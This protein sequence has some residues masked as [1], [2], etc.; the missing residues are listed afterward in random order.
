MQESC[1]EDVSIVSY[2]PA[3]PGELG[4]RVVL[5]ADPEGSLLDP[6]PDPL[7][8]CSHDCPLL[9]ARVCSADGSSSPDR[10]AIARL[11]DSSATLHHIM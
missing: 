3:S 9:M 8:A 6:V 10:L 5:L 1:A 7:L 4:L 11:M 2:V